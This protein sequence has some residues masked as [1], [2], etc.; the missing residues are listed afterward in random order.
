MNTVLY[1]TLIKGVAKAGK[2]D[3]ALHVFE[4]MRDQSVER[5][6]VT[7]SI[8]VKA[9]HDAGVVEQGLLLLGKMI[10]DEHA[11][12]ESNFNNLPAGA[13]VAGSLEAD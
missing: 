4:Q 1:T 10:E 9:L 5:D 12:D 11:P 3:K 2:K 8:R 13:V 6:C 7:Y